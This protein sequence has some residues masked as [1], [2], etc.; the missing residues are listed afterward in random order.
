MTIITVARDI[1]LVD[2]FLRFSSAQICPRFVRRTSSA[3]QR[4]WRM[5]ASAERSPSQSSDWTDV[6]HAS[7]I[8]AREGQRNSRS[9][10]ESK[11]QLGLMSFKVR[12]V[13]RSRRAGCSAPDLEVPRR[14]HERLA[15][16]PRVKGRT[17]IECLT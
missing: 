12:Q 1:D 2:H 15:A 13:E 11:P 3:W 8:S 9:K 16:K 5:P 17:D 7:L 14:G 6:P 4:S 10:F